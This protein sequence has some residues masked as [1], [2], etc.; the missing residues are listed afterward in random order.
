M[1]AVAALADAARGACAVVV[2]AVDAVVTGHVHVFGVQH[3]PFIVGIGASEW[4]LLPEEV[5]AEGIVDIGLF[6][7]AH[8]GRKYVNLT[9]QLLDAAGF[10]QQFW[11]VEN[12]RRM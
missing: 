2:E 5:N 7:Q 10:T 1:G 3:D 4:T 6:E 8:D 12:K 11:G 9:A